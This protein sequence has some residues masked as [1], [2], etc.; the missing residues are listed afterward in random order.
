MLNE[1]ADHLKDPDSAR[2]SQ[3]QVKKSER[4]H[5][6]VLC[7]VVN[8]KNGFGGYGEPQRFTAVRVEATKVVSV[9][10]DQSCEVASMNADMNDSLDYAREV[11]SQHK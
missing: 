9:A 8:A 1:V 7:G 4:E 10:F 2:F 11:L 6:T 3:I 5:R